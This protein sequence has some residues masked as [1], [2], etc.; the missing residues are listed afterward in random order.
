M[1][2]RHQSVDLRLAGGRILTGPLA[3]QCI[4]AAIAGNQ[5]SHQVQGSLLVV[6][7]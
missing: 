1:I 4:G 5:H 3:L 6:R 7:W 2:L